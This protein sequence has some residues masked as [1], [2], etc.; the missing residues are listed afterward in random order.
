MNTIYDWVTIIIFAG[1]VILFLHRSDQDEPPADALWQ[2]LIAGAGCAIVNWLG[3]K[4]HHLAAIG[5]GFCLIIY[6]LKI[7][8]P[9][10]RER[11]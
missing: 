6:I 1:L 9:F 8:Y 5:L 11:M 2:Y 3:N 10:P 4:A 7:L